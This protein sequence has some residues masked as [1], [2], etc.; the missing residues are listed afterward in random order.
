MNNAIL[1][2]SDL[3]FS[4]NIDITRFDNNF[5]N[6][7]IET[8]KAIT[9]FKIKYLVITGD[10]ANL[11]DETEYNTAKTFLDVIVSSL[12]I[13]KMNVI[14]C[15]GNHDI[16]YPELDNTAYPLWSSKKMYNFAA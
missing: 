1:H 11:S 12:D 8:L 3:H 5:Q 2:I 4:S 16:S 7:F 9:D 10:I 6:K 13:N 15:P 14:I